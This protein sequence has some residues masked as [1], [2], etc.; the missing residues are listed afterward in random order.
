MVSHPISCHAKPTSSL[1]ELQFVEFFAGE[2]RVWRTMRVD[3]VNSVG[4]DYTYS[5]GF[6][7]DHNPF[8]ILSDSGFGFHP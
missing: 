4:V 1:Q 2:G 3:S 6:D 8:D 5:D 7:D